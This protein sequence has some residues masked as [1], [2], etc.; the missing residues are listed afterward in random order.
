MKRDR[1]YYVKHFNACVEDA[2]K[3]FARDLFPPAIPSGLD[4]VTSAARRLP[5]VYRSAFG[6]PV[7]AL[8]RKASQ[9]DEYLTAAVNAIVQRTH[10]AFRRETMAFEEVVADV[11]HGFLSNVRRIGAWKPDHTI[12][13]P[14]VAWGPGGPDYDGPYTY[15]AYPDEGIRAGIV[16]LPWSHARHSLVGWAMLAH[17]AAG[18]DIVGARENLMAEIARNL[19]NRGALE[20]DGLGRYFARYLEEIVSDIMG[21]LNMGP[22]AAVAMLAYFRGWNAASG[23]GRHL[24][25]TQDDDHH[26]IE[27]VRPL[28]LA[29]AIPLLGFRGADDWHRIVLSM[30]R[31]EYGKWLRIGRARISV[32]RATEAARTVAQTIATRPLNEMG[33]LTLAGI[34]NWQ[35]YDEDIATRLRREIRGDIAIPKRYG[36]EFY[37]SHAVSAGV[38]ES[39]RGRRSVEVVFQRTIEVLQRMRKGTRKF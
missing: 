34:Q 28:V 2:Q 14:L 5:K 16:V 13:A 20:K 30:A 15:P 8:L 27:A 22:A 38:I 26:P 21:V 25:R 12:H 31:H 11:Y 19:R 4:N 18:H 35:D 7:C 17:E 37:A 10:H 32:D 39:L 23:Y 24:S 6:R 36:R 3:A 29:Q 9:P 33:R 1:S